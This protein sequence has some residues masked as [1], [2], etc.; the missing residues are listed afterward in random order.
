[1]LEP[2]P[3]VFGGDWAEAALDGVPAI[4]SV[5]Q[6]FVGRCQACGCEAEEQTDGSVLVDPLVID[7]TLMAARSVPAASMRT[8]STGLYSHCQRSRR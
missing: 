2:R 5:L 4:E 3:L 7:G 8:R 1:M 6:V